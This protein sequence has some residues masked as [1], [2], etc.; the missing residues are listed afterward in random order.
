MKKI[1]ETLKRKWAEYLIEII[2]IVIGILGAYAL[3]NWNE[4]R[5]NNNTEIKILNE[6]RNDLESNYYEISNIKKRTIVELKRT[7]SLIYFVS[8]GTLDVE[9]HANLFDHLD[10]NVI[11]IF[12]NSNSTYRYIASKGIEII[13]NDSLRIS[14]S[15]IY[16]RRFAN[17]TSRETIYRNFI[18]NE[19]AP[20][21]MSN[22]RTSKKEMP[23]PIDLNKLHTEPKFINLL[24]HKSHRLEFSRRA[25]ESGLAELEILLTEVKIEIENL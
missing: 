15:Y 3:N 20:Y 13:S 23:I 2:V 25:L 10:Q 12:N 7:D 24:I 22:F 18:S 11:G 8:N 6:L 21:I 9:N 14:I 16:E 5:K 1:L 19:I 17:I 4:D